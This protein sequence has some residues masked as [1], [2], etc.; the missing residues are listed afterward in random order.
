M[1][2][3]NTFQNL[4]KQVMVLEYSDSFIDKQVTRLRGQ[5]DRAVTNLMIK[6]LIVRFDQLKTGNTKEQIKNL[7]KNFIENK[8]WVSKTPED[9][10][11]LKKLLANPLQIEFYNFD[12]LESVVHSFRDPKQKQE[13]KA[14]QKQPGNTGAELIYKDSKGLQIY[15]GKNANQCVIFKNYLLNKNKK[16]LKNSNAYG[17]CISYGDG[18]SYFGQYRFGKSGDIESSASVYFVYDETLPKTD[19]RHVIVIHAEKNGKYRL[20]DAFNNREVS[21]VDWNTVI[22]SKWQPK[23]A[24][25]KDLIKYVPF[26]E[27]E[28]IERELQGIT[29]K[30]FSKLSYKA[31]KSYM[32]QGK[33]IFSKD[34]VLLPSE[35]QH[36]YINARTPDGGQIDPKNTMPYFIMALT[37]LTQLFA[38]DDVSASSATT[39]ARQP[40]SPTSSQQTLL[41]TKIK[42]AKELKT[43]ILNKGGNI[44]TDKSWLKPLLSDKTI[45]QSKKKETINLW[46][47]LIYD[48]VEGLKKGTGS[49]AR[50]SQIAGAQ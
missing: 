49:A 19:G 45:L 21:N 27:E 5:A 35:L 39:N 23:L 48:I 29:P 24:P 50:A 4:Y 12:E 44:D 17:W 9:E 42:E 8:Q 2:R 1:N 16:E 26:S 40:G 3:I 10:I 14:A 47:K 6:E 31:K 13:I 41:F 43:D 36:T 22:S 38:D 7:V 25:H 37:K 11:R 18:R 46:Q 32:E 30:G 20:T 33:S 28:N 34:Y 15:F